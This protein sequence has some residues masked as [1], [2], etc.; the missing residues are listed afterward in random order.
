MRAYTHLVLGRVREHKVTALVVVSVRKVENPCALILTAQNKGRQ[1][2]AVGVELALTTRHRDFVPS[3]PSY[4]LRVHKREPELWSGLTCVV[5]IFRRALVYVQS[6]GG[7]CIVRSGVAAQT[8][9]KTLLHGK[10]PQIDAVFMSHDTSH[11]FQEA[12]V[13]QMQSDVARRCCELELQVVL[14]PR[15]AL[16]LSVRPWHHGTASRHHFVALPRCHHLRQ[17]HAGAGVAARS[18]LTQPAGLQRHRQELL[19]H[20]KTAIVVAKLVDVSGPHAC[21]IDHVARGRRR[22]L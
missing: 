13:E 21:D 22:V 7:L 1:G 3:N 9:D 8:A 4:S 18:V 14:L 2:T 17:L 15:S 20:H 16:M 5:V 19:V 12:Y 6:T 10:P 11:A